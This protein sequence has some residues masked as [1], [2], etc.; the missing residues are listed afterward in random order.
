M[1]LCHCMF[2]QTF[3]IHEHGLA[4]STE[5]TTWNLR[6]FHEDSYL[7]IE[8]KITMKSRT[9]LVSGY[10]GG[11][12][13]SSTKHLE[14]GAAHITRHSEGTCRMNQGGGIACPCSNSLKA[15]KG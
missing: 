1:G 6:P 2:T 4:C 12:A 7:Q 13:G 3:V 14:A 11:P 10:R 8:S 15:G 9:Q 5:F